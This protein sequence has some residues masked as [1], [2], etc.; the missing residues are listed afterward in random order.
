M[1]RTLK[2]YLGRDCIDV[3]YSKFNYRYPFEGERMGFNGAF[4]M[5]KIKPCEHLG[6]LFH[7]YV[8]I[9]A[10]NQI[11]D[12]SAW[13]IRDLQT[14]VKYGKV[15]K[16]ILRFERWTG[17]YKVTYR[18]PNDTMYGETWEYKIKLP[19]IVPGDVVLNKVVEEID[20]ECHE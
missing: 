11:I 6:Y 14:L 1:Q 10:D 8:D 9:D 19:S 5:I 15:I 3:A 13:P 4:N 2:L 7:P 16:S 20:L 18:I 17:V 12:V